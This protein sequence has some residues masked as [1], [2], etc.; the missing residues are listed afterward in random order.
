[1][2]TAT[3][4]VEIRGLHKS[5]WRGAS[6][7]PV[8]SDLSLDIA[9]GEFVAL[10]GPSGSGKSTLLNLIAGLDRPTR[11]SLRIDGRELSE[12]SE[13]ELDRWRNRRV[14]FIFQFYNL[15]PVLSALENVEIPLLISDYGGDER[16][17]RCEAALR[18]VGLGHRLDHRPGELS[19]GEQQRVAIARALVN[20]PPLLLADEPTGNL[21]PALA[22]DI[23][24]IIADAHARGTTVLVATHDPTLLERYRHRRIVLDGGRVAGDRAPETYALGGARAGTRA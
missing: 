6:E 4:L 13:S 14:G 16:R 17:E 9:R 8:L 1:V 22:L 19:G 18:I 7:V 5:Y 2:S 20:D 15:I 10:M 23:M 12:F 21:D 3:A 11:G 24:D